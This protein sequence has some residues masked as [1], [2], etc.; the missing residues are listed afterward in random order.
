MNNKDTLEKIRAT[1][2]LYA[3]NQYRTD[4]EREGF[5]EISN[6]LEAI[7]AKPEACSKTKFPH[8]KCKSYDECRKEGAC[9]DCWNC[10]A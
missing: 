9:L 1:A 7:M 10:G 5:R 8:E 3:N 2:T 6:R 4:A